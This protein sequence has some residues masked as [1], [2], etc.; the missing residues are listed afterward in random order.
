MT[1]FRH[2]PPVGRL[3]IIAVGV[4]VLGVAAI[5]CATS[6]NAI[7]RLVDQLG[8]YDT[9]ITRAFPILLDT[10]FIIAELAAVLGGI[11][12]AVT[13]SDDVTK[14]WPYTAMLVCGLGTL[15]FNIGHALTLGHDSLTVWRC[16]VASLPPV[17]MIISFQVLIALTRWVMLH[18][19]R[20]L[21]SAAALSPTTM[22]GYGPAV[23]RRPD[24]APEW[25]VPPPWAPYAHL[26]S[27]APS[28]P[29]SA[30]STNGHP[31]NGAGELNG[32]ATDDITKRAMAE[33]YLS[34][35]APDALQVATGSSVVEALAAR[36]VNIS[37]RE[38]NRVI[39]QY[40]S[41]QQAAKRKR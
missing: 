2:L 7:L 39:D 27:P 18:L 37:G 1:K 35:L 17:L 34:G 22:P 9:G 15:G 31:G 14:G 23:I 24:G 6:Y 10:A 40:R 41:A 29:S 28:D 8:L 11:M 13:N 19:G 4:G 38:A 32:T 3:I 26:G 30:T 16:I 5:A 33:M 21:N 36:G 12:R 20:P 25:A